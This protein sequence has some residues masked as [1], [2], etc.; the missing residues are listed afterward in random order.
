MEQSTYGFSKHVD[1]AYERVGHPW[2]NAILERDDVATADIDALSRS[3]GLLT[4]VGARTSHAAV[5]ARQ[6]N[7]AC[8]V[9]CRELRLSSPHSCRLGASTLTEG[10]AI[11]LDGSTGLIYD[12]QLEVVREVPETLLA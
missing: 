6:L 4:H 1:L 2:H 12:G 11:T 3:C 5:V 10:A 8:I 7:K 9:G